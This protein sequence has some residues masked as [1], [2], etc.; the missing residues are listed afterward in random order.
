MAVNI[1]VSNGN[2]MYVNNNNNNVILNS[3]ISM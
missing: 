2:V 1:H 3:N